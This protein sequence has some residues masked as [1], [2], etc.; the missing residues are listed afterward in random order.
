MLK[1][2]KWFNRI[3][4]DIE[5]RWKS[6]VKEKVFSENFGRLNEGL[7]GLAIFKPIEFKKVVFWKTLF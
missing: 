1:A 3:F 5:F 4:A 6:K 7:V 2:L